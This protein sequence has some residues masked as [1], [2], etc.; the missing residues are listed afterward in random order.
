MQG[1]ST[2]AIPIGY[3]QGGSTY[4]GS[5]ETMTEDEIE[6]QSQSLFVYG[7]GWL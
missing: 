4:G 5:K 1:G 2:L 7:S 3:T 6:I